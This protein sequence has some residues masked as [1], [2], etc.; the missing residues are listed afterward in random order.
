MSGIVCPACGNSFEPEA[1][2][3][4]ATEAT[5]PKG[6]DMKKREAAE[7]MVNGAMSFDDVREHVRRAL[8]VRA[9]QEAPDDYGRWV[10]VADLTDTEVVYACG[11]DEL[12]QCSYTITAAGVVTLGEPEKVVRTYAPPPAGEDGDGVTEASDRIYGRVLEAK[13]DDADG[14]R[15][16]RVRIIAYGDSKNGR[17]YSEQCHVEGRPPVRGRAGLRPSPLR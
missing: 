9:Q 2:A 12:H 17:R 8:S 4:R 5:D 13:G 15:V 11:T 1:A 7:A 16:F 3:V 10:M 6:E 14:G